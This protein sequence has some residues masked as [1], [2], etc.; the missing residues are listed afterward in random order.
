MKFLTT[1][2]VFVVSALSFLEANDGKVVTYLQNSAIPVSSATDLTPLIERIG[3]SRYVLLGESSHGTHEYY[4]WRKRISKRLIEEKNFSF[5]AV[6]GDWSSAYELNK[7]VKNQP[8]AAANAREAVHAF[9]RWPQWMWANEETIALVEWLREYNS[10]KPEDQK[11]GFYGIDL[12]AFD[13]SMDEVISYL[14]NIDVE[15]AQLATQAYSCLSPFRENMHDYVRAVFSGMDDCAQRAESVVELL[16]S[17]AP[18]DRCQYHF[19]A[20]QNALVVRNAERHFRAMASRDQTSWNHRVDNFKQTVEKLMQ[21]YGAESRG[22]VWAHNTHVGDARATSMIHQGME[23]IGKML[24]EKHEEENVFI[25]GFSTNRG[26]VVAGTQ[27]GS[28]MQ[29]MQ[30]PQGAEGSAEDLFLESGFE[31]ALFL[32]DENTP[33]PLFNGIGHRAKGVVYNPAQEH[34]NYVPTILPRRYDAFF[35]IKETSALKALQ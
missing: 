19:N 6:E 26:E 23:N 32:F 29:I 4:I 22:I 16:H 14:Q 28:P 15:K 24:R 27:W 34:G 35:F 9:K 25:V 20:L 3:E 8:G 31:K 7:Y 30:I 1:L 17:L 33:E 11:V 18:E 13:E 5:I 10:D 21:Y 12:Y 2:S